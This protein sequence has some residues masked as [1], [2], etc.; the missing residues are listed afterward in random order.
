VLTHTRWHRDDLAARLLRKMVER[1]A[2]QWD[3]LTLPAVRPEGAGAACDPRQPGEALWPEFK[4]AE[5]LEII[6][7]QD[8]RAYAA[9]YQQDPVHGATVEWPAELFGDW[10]WTPPEHWPRKF[11]VRVVCIDPSK[12]RSDK[13]GD[14]SA[15]VFMGIT[16]DRLLYVDALVERIPL[17]QIVRKALV[18][19][20]QHKPECVGIEADQFQELLTHEFQR[21][22]RERMRWSVCPMRTDG[23]PKVSRIRRLSQYIIHREFRFK[24]DSPGCR[25]L[26]DQLMDFPLADHDD[27]PDALEMC[28]RLPSILYPPQDRI[29][30][31]P[32][33]SVLGGDAWQAAHS[34][35]GPAQAPY[36][37]PASGCPGT[38]S[39]ISLRED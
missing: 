13:Q 39:Q 12:G 8:L 6:R 9:L 33:S 17:D 21:Q 31:V 19:C 1:G 2:E 4:S 3:I 18:F 16:E 29:F 11:K 14:Y 23:V 37:L 26:V 38:P 36:P 15:I 28:I 27:G 25:L 22:C 30:W 5:D 35:C 34:V 10:I 20:D 7:R 32:M 24:A